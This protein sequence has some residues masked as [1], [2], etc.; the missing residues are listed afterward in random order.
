MKD[1]RSDENKY[2]QGVNMSRRSFIN[3]AALIGMGSAL[4]LSPLAGFAAEATPKKGGVLK[5]GMSGGNTSD[6]LDPTLFSD[7]VPLNQAYM[8]M[9][10]LVEIDETNQATPE[11][12]ESW[13]AKPGAQEWTFKV[14]QGV[15]FHNGKTLTVEDI[16]YSINLHRGDQS[17]SAIKTQLAAIKELKKSGDNEITL[18]LDSGNADLPFLLADY[19][20]VVVP[21]GF[22][23]WKHPIGT[24]GFVF[25]QYQPGVRSYF[26]RNPNY[27][28]PNRAF[29]DAV[30]VL[31]INDATARTN[32]LISGQVHAINRVDFKTVDFLKRSPALNIVRA[33]GGQHFTFLMDCRVAPFNNNDVRTAIKYGIDR[34]KLLATVLRGYGSLGNDHP[35]PK[36][37]RF[38]NKS[39]EQR[40]YDPDKA[41]FFLKKAG[42]SALPIELSS[43]DAAFAGA[44]DAA[45]L[46]QG[47]A[48]AAGIQVSIKRQ[49]ADSYW[50]DVWMKAPFS[51]GYWGGRPTADQMFSTAWQSTAKWNDT[52][53]KNDKF[54]SL[55][56]Q[57]RSLLDEQ[58]RAEIYGELQS[59]A[60]DD[61]GA[62]IPLFGD[63]LDAASKKVG[64]VKPHPLFNFMGGR[65]A[66]RVW[67][68]S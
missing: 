14:R 44:L 10:G 3:T 58:K 11:L 65:L 2:L 59:I 6:S 53:W 67:L 9:N 22:T 63:Y 54:D 66:E 42:L 55:L 7:W 61:G 35:I 50:D 57:A 16:L 26:K 52:H 39:L 41:K 56:I 29:V 46:F 32:A 12:L 43:S 45:A 15:T 68:E 31:V 5:L 19:H 20:L 21:D 18:T 23:D 24:G 33:A 13:V 34:E 47:E 36:T 38:F 28:K 48:A 64:G 60:R 1:D 17:R 37:D 40:A 8:L 51:M 25:D 4:S 30:E 49:P 27:W 62:M